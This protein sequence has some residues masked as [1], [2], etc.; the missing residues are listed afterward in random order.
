MMTGRSAL[1]RRAA[2]LVN[3]EAV[4]SG[5]VETTQVYINLRQSAQ[6]LHINHKQPL[7]LVGSHLVRLRVYIRSSFVSKEQEGKIVAFLR[8]SYR[9]GFSQYS[10]SD[11]L[12]KRRC[13]HPIYK[14]YQSSAYVYT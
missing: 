12:L 4:L 9:C 6:Q 2:E 8:R 14:Y 1:V 11:K 13:P 3:V 10:P 5:V 7:S